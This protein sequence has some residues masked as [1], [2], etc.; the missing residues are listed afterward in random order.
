MEVYIIINFK[1]GKIS[2]GTHKLSDNCINNNK[3]IKKIKLNSSSSSH[4]PGHSL[5]HSTNTPFL[6]HNTLSAS[7]SGN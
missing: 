4:S 5:I 1:V 7:N 3:K 2:Q 6:S